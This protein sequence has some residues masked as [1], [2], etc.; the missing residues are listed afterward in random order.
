MRGYETVW[1]GARCRVA[2]CEPVVCEQVPLP[3]HDPTGITPLHR[4]YEPVRQAL[5]FDALRLSTRAPTLLPRVFFAGPH[6]CFGARE[7]SRSRAGCL[8]SLTKSSTLAVTKILSSSKAMSRTPG[9]FIPS[10]LRSRTWHA[11]MPSSVHNTLA[12]QGDRFSSSSSFTFTGPTDLGVRRRIQLGE[13][14]VLRF[15][16]RVVLAD[17]GEDGL[18]AKDVRVDD[19][20]L[21]PR[22]EAFELALDLFGDLIE[23]QFEHGAH[24]NLLGLLRSGERL[25]NELVD[26]LALFNARLKTKHDQDAE[27]DQGGELEPRRALGTKEAVLDLGARTRVLRRTGLVFTAPWPLEGNPPSRW[28]CALPVQTYMDSPVTALSDR[29]PLERFTDRIERRNERCFA[30]LT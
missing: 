4:Y 5:T 30:P 10:L 28:P 6:V 13:L 1:F 21:L 14:D 2:P 7:P 22:L 27:V 19:D 17:L 8:A 15:Q 9:S 16:V 23:F 12:I 24:L 20:L 29:E 25:G 26:L 3:V 11:S 18:T